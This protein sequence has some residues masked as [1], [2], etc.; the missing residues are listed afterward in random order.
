MEGKIVRAALVGFDT[1]GPSWG[2]TS[3]ECKSSHLA[4]FSDGSTPQRGTFILWP[5]SSESHGEMLQGSARDE[6]CKTS[7]GF[8]LYSDLKICHFTKNEETEAT[9]NLFAFLLDKQL[10]SL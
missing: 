4:F 8:E 9:A 3:C 6:C 10:F 7:L 2:C 5:V 1:I